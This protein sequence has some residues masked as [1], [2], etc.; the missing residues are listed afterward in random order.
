M[1]LMNNKIMFIYGTRPEAIK[2]A[3]LIKELKQSA[4]LDVHIVSSDQHQEILKHV[5]DWFEFAP[6]THLNIMKHGA[7]ISNIVEV[8]LGRLDTIIK[9][10]A[11]NLII[12]HGDTATTL[13]GALAGY[14]N[15]VPVAH[16][17][18]GLR[19]NSKYL[20]WPEE[21]NRRF[22][23]QIADFHFTATHKATEQLMSEGVPGPQIWE[24]GNTVIDALYWTLAKIND[25]EMLLRTSPQIFQKF[26]SQNK[27]ITVTLHR[28]ENWGAPITRI[29]DALASLQSRYVDTEI[30]FVTHPNPVVKETVLSAL[31][32]VPRIHFLEPLEYDKFCLLMSKSHIILSDS[33]GIQEEAP[34]LNIPVL[35]LREST[36][37]PEAVD[38]G[39]VKLVGTDEI[40]ILT[41]LERLLNDQIHYTKM[42]SAVN[43]FGDGTAA[44]KI[45]QIIQRNILQC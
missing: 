20:P 9:D 44:K 19:T 6:D 37:R 3:P 7:S 33:G 8:A 4:I 32:D 13:S 17:E 14:F 18:A 34:S 1:S 43:P 21:G 26:N 23:G 36:E 2:L 25:G 30:V 12:V 39:A 27:L 40:K 38:S 42:S 11:P 24:T 35:L 22:V 5:H 31:K 29:C 16:V 15:K 10:I 28:R 41:E 45:A